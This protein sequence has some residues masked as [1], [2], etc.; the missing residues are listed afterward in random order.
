MVTDANQPWVSHVG[1]Q[2]RRTIPEG[3]CR[4]GHRQDVGPGIPRPKM[5]LC[6]GP[7]FGATFCEQFGLIMISAARTK[8]RNAT[9]KN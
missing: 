6:G 8:E 9:P 1:Q 7:I 4:F 2:D 3:T 5:G